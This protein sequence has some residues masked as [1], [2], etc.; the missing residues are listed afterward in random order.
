MHPGDE[1]RVADLRRER[2]RELGGL[3]GAG[4]RAH[5]HV[6]RDDAGVE[7][8]QGVRVVHT[9][10]VQLVQRGL[11]Q[12]AGVTEFTGEVVG[13][14]A[15]AQGGHPLGQRRVPEAPL[16]RLEPLLGGLQ[17]PGLQR[18]FAEPEQ[19]GGLLGDESVRVRLRE[20]HR[21]LLRR[22]LG[23]AGR[24][25]AL[26]V[27]EPQPQP[28]REMVRA[29]GRQLLVR[30][31]EPLGYVPQR[32]LRGAYPPRLQRRDVGGRVRRFRQ[33]FLC[34]PAFRTQLLDPAPD[35]LRAVTLRH[36]LSMP[37]SP[38]NPRRL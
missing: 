14:G 12:V 8:Q 26:R 7:K 3:G 11:E 28:G 19:C 32:G 6:G 38:L 4:V 27:G 17:V 29:A 2:E 15:A 22:D 5:V 35:D 34:Q 20:E 23:L 37:L 18:A 9:G 31:P 16:R 13:D 33:L 1:R 30:H 10:P 36:G 24:E 25:G 21:V